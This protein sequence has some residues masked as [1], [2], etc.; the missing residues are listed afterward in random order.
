MISTYGMN[1]MLA[2]TLV[3]RERD[4]FEEG[5]KND[6]MSKREI[7]SFKEKI[8]DIKSVDD[9]MK[10]YSTYSF[11]M[12]AFG[13]EKEIPSKAMVKK[14]MTSDP[15]DRTSLVNKMTSNAYK[16]MNKTLEFDTDGKAGKNFAD[17]EWQEK[18]VQRYLDQRLV[19]TQREVNPAVARAIGFQDKAAK[20]TDWY[21]ILADKDAS[22][23][24]R[25]VLGLPDSMASADIDAQ[26]RMFEKK[27]DIKDLQDPEKVEKLL[28]KYAAIASVT[29]AAPMQGTSVLSLFSNSTNSGM[30]S[31][32]TLDLS[33][34]SSARGY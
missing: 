11:V 29:E 16:E 23:I 33:L 32:A 27:M 13:M 17:P 9:L 5:I 3:N 22:K 2:Y 4:K 14:L 8:A 10:D 25:T 34:V 15:D 19:D 26:K 30:W 24:M 20:M 21:K 28:K 18:M 6:P 31:A 1:T 7:A 12:K